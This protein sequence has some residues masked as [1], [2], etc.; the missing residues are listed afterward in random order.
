MGDDAW[1]AAFVAVSEPDKCA[2]A[3]RWLLRLRWS[4]V[5]D[6]RKD[7]EHPGVGVPGIW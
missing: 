5:R 3:I 2:V 4:V 6:V 1:C 7:D